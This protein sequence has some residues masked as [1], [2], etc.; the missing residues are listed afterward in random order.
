MKL[1]HLPPNL[2]PQYDAEQPGAEDRQ[3]RMENFQ[4]KYCIERPF[5]RGEHFPILI[6]ELPICEGDRQEILRFSDTE[7]FF[8]IFFIFIFFFFHSRG[9]GRQGK[10]KLLTF[11]QPALYRRQQLRVELTAYRGL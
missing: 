2:T 4:T 9:D 8:L 5:A 1:V 3:A 10:G 7:N 11:Y 6:Q